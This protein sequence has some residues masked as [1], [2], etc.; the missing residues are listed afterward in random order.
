LSDKLTSPN[1]K[2]FELV[3][4]IIG[5][6]KGNIEK[7]TVV[8]KRQDLSYEDDNLRRLIATNDCLHVQDSKEPKSHHTATVLVDG[9]TRK[10][11]GEVIGRILQ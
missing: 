6:P 10:N 4:K 7:E 3:F 9:R 2:C 11:L 5:I 8:L 1:N